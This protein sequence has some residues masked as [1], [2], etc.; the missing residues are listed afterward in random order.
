MKRNSIKRVN[1]LLEG[2]TRKREKPGIANDT[3]IHAFGIFE[4]NL[5]NMSMCSSVIENPKRHL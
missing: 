4:Y 3:T 2:V 1:S 5:I